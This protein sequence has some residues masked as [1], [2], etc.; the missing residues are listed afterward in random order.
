MMELPEDPHQN[1][2]DEGHSIWQAKVRTYFWQGGRWRP[3]ARRLAILFSLL[4]NLVLILVLGILA[5]QLFTIKNFVNQDIIKGL[6]TNFVLMDRAHITTTVQVSDTIK[7]IDVIPV[8]FDLQLAQDT[9]V[10]LTKDTAIEDATIYLN[11][12][13]VPLDLTLRAGTALNINLDLIVPV[14]QTI[15]VVLDVPVRMEIPV[16]IALV[17]TKLHE[18][19]I[20]LQ[21][22][23]APYYWNLCCG[24]NSWS[25]YP[26]C[27][28]VVMRQICE[29]V[30]L[31]K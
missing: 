10:V 22:V 29:W 9:E 7:V 24:K 12:Q 23:L 27:Q 30:L 13:P 8:V 31:A 26:F 28:G 17:D 2:F 14:S 19:F 15:P 11:N 1:S 6:Y 21:E 4:T 18:P 3:A 5:Q 25:E 16:D 20:G